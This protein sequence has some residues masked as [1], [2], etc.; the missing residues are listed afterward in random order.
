MLLCLAADEWSST[1]WGFRA[2]NATARG[3]ALKS[4]P[5]PGANR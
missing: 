1:L 5:G 2:G 3:S 4:R